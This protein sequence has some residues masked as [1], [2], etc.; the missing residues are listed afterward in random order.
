MYLKHS[1]PKRSNSSKNEQEE[2]VSYCCCFKEAEGLFLPS[3]QGWVRSQKKQMAPSS[4]PFSCT[5][6]RLGAFLAVVIVGFIRHAGRCHL[7][8]S[9][10]SFLHLGSIDTDQAKLCVF[11]S[12][13]D[14]ELC[15]ERQ[16]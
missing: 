13:T 4:L 8:D 1:L 3:K 15:G 10:L 5:T 11:T 14:D 16:S 9:S 7:R 6:V 2:M 12:E